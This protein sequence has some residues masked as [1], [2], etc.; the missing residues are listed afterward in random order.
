MKKTD[1][2][3]VTKAAIKSIESKVKSQAEASDDDDEVE[4][5]Q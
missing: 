2:E 3:H 1:K 5:I 4:E